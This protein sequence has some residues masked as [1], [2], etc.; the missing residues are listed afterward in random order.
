[1]KSVGGGKSGTL[2]IS[3]VVA[4]FYHRWYTLLASEEPLAAM[5]PK[6]GWTKD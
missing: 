3:H 5:F 2:S 4:I 6:P 1:M